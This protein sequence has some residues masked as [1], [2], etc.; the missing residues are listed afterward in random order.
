[1][2]DDHV[3]EETVTVRRLRTAF[4]VVIAVLLICSVAL[5][6]AQ[7]F[8]LFNQTYKPKAGTALAKA[9]CKICHTKPSDG[10]LNPYGAELKGKA[11]SAASLKSIEKLD[12]DKDGVNNIT[13]IKAGTL[14]GDP[15][16]KPA[17]PACPPK[18][19]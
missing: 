12:A 4:V 5:A 11:I 15:K 2:L 3:R 14:P 7:W 6:T 13:E 16:S 8:K 18:K 1:M 10:P 17:A 9:G 19:K